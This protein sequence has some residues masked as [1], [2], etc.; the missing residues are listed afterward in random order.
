[1]ISNAL[2]NSV[3]SVSIN[4][5]S[6]TV[7]VS[8]THRNTTDKLVQSYTANFEKVRET[9]LLSIAASRK[10]KTAI[11]W[12]AYLSREKTVFVKSLNKHVKTRLTFITLT[13]PNKQIHT[14]TEIKEKC[15]GPFL[16]WLRDKHKATKYIWKAEIQKN[17]NIHFHITTDKFIHYQALRKQ[18]NRN[19]DQLGYCKRYTLETGRISPPSTEIKSVRKVKNIAAYLGSYLSG[20]KASK[21]KKSS[22]EYNNRIIG[23]RLWGVSSYLTRLKNPQITEENANF[24]E[25]LKYLQGTSHGQFRTDYTTTFFISH[26]IL[27]EICDVFTDVLGFDWLI[28]SGLDF[29]DIGICCPSLN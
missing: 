6:A 24:N 26:D 12:M 25:L 14:D 1:M 28:S 16:Q 3:L 2:D 5:S 7:F 11:N 8:R 27:D 9:N 23:G 21:G 20:T 22:Q 29:D 15:L 18:W 19:L 4:P 10:L 17:G 13:L